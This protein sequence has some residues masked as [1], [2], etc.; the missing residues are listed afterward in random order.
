MLRKG[1]EWTLSLPLKPGSYSY[2][3][4]VDGVWKLDLRIQETVKT[5][6]GAKLVSGHF[7]V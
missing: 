3:F 1:N 2:K 5:E 6:W 7:Q 4:I